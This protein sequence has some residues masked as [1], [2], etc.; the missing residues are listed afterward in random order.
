MFTLLDKAKSDPE[1][2][3]GLNLAAVTWTAIQVTK[4]T[5]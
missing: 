5:L 2:I 3:R 4:L 1:N